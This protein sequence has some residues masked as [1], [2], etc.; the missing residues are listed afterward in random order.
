MKK[1]GFVYMQVYQKLRCEIESGT[2]MPDSQLPTEIA[3]AA[4]FGVSRDTVRRALAKLEIEGYIARKAATGTFARKRK[5]DYSL[6][7]HASF[8]EQMR[9]MGFVPSSDINSIKISTEFPIEITERLKT[10]LNEKIYE[11]CRLRRANGEPMAY[12]VVYIPQKFCP[13]IHTHIVE[14]T[15]IY[16][17]YENH[18]G[19]K[20]GNISVQ[21]EA[22]SAKNES[23]RL[24][25]LA[26]GA[27][28]LKVTSLMH[29]QDTR[30]LYYAICE[31]IGWKYV[32]SAVLPRGTYE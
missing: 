32:F 17:L 26:S 7:T 2:F 11:I 31:H 12:E 18:Y 9:A 15:S 3:L 27:P 25:N 24:L 29:L 6:L 21:V 10:D 13:N 19:L 20:M 5:A 28:I 22:I 4:D 14:D 1:K 23:Q 8:S 16:E 30:P